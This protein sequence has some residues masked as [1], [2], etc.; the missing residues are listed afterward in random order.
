M[1]CE[2]GKSLGTVIYLAGD[3]YAVGDGMEGNVAKYLANRIEFQFVPQSDLL[4]FD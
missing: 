1:N 3:S 4:T 2:A